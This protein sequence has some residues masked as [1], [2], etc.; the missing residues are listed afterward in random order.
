MG[1]R[2]ITEEDLPDVLALLAEGFPRRRPAY[3]RRGLQNMCLLPEVPGY[4]KYGYLLEESDTA[5]G[6]ILLLSTLVNNTSVRSNNSCWYVREGYRAKAAILYKRATTGEGVHV[7]FSP[8]EHVVPI[9]LACGFRQYTSGVCL[10]DGSAA[11]RPAQGWRVTRYTPDR[12]DLTSLTVE[13]ADRHVRYGCSV[14]LLEN[15]NAPIEL[16]VYRLKLI[17]GVIPC[18][19]FLHGMP[20]HVLA[21]SGPLMRHLLTRGI[22]LALVDIDETT[23]TVG[24]R[25]FPGHNVRYGKGGTPAIGDLLDSEFALFGP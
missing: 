15:D 4:P 2:E 6:V 7:N 16:L 23:E 8:A 22:L 18:A 25:S 14:L 3:W 1:I 20:E 11:L 9:T 24:F 5:E 13:I 10:I 12:T 17:K 21:A 19:Q